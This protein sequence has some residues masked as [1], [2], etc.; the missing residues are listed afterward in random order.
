M[1]GNPAFRDALLQRL[2]T[3]G[4]MGDYV[5]IPKVQQ[6]PVAA[7]GSGP[8]YQMGQ[9]TGS[10]SPI[11]FGKWLQK[12]GF[13]VSEHPAFGGV[14]PV[15]VKNSKHYSQRAFDVNYGRGGTSRQETDAINRILKVAAKYGLK[16]IW[17]APG[18]YNHA[19]FYW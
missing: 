19:H 18:H 4:S 1:A 10:M 17:Q 7:S 9:A 15:H 6:A 12:Q 8:A 2:D 16:Y 14:E 11:D 5:P 13:R 3:I